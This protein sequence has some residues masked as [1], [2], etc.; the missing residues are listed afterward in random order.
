VFL[1]SVSDRI[2]CQVHGHIDVVQILIQHG[3]LPT[4]QDAKGFNCLCLALHHRAFTCA[5]W[6]LD[7]PFAGKLLSQVSIL[8]ETVLHIAV[9]AFQNGAAGNEALCRRIFF[10]LIKGGVSV[11]DHRSIQGVT[12][13][14]KAIQVQCQWFTSN[15]T[16]YASAATTDSILQRKF[17][18]ES[19]FILF[20]DPN[21]CD[22]AHNPMLY[23]AVCLRDTAAV[24]YIA[25]AGADVNRR[26]PDGW[27]PLLAAAA[28]GDGQICELLLNKS[29]NIHATLPAG[30]N[31]TPLQLAAAAG[32]MDVISRLLSRGAPLDTR[33]DL[34][35]NAVHLALL[36][37]Y[38]EVAFT[39]VS[40][41]KA[42]G[43]GGTAIAELICT[44]QPPLLHRILCSDLVESVMLKCVNMLLLLGFHIDDK[45]DEGR[46]PLQVALAENLPLVAAA[47]GS[48]A[49]SVSGD[50]RAALFSAADARDSVSLRTMIPHA[51][52]LNCREFFDHGRPLLHAVVRC[53][54]CR[55]ESVNQGMIECIGVMASNPQCN[56]DVADD[57]G[58]TPLHVA[59]A[60]GNLHAVSALLAAGAQCDSTS[61]SSSALLASLTSKDLGC[62]D[63]L[64]QFGAN[65]MSPLGPHG[66]LSCVIAAVGS[67][68]AAIVNRVME[69]LRLHHSNAVRLVCELQ[70]ATDGMTLPLL[71]LENSYECDEVTLEVLKS[72]ILGGSDALQCNHA[73]VYPAQI[74]AARSFQQTALFISSVAQSHLLSI[75]TSPSPRPQTRAEILK[76]IAG[77]GRCDIADSAGLLP[78]HLCAS[79]GSFVALEAL[80]SSSVMQG[81]AA[82]NS[83]DANGHNALC[84]AVSNGRADLLPILLR[85]KV[86]HLSSCGCSALAH[87]VVAQR[88]DC[89][90]V[91]LEHSGQSATSIIGRQ[92]PALGIDSL[93][94]ACLLGD[95][96]VVCALIE[97]S[98][99]PASIFEKRYDDGGSILHYL[100]S[101]QHH[102][103]ADAP[104]PPSVAAPHAA[105]STLLATALASAGAPFLRRN[106]QV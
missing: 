93:Q 60:L 43:K 53:S 88:T 71:W 62:V 105:V 102:K 40:S 101:L 86:S 33:N 100:A 79:I 32:A 8:G 103:R 23:V 78:L 81:A 58:C 97:A 2:S 72:L 27:T 76:C 98:K 55:G 42:A 20:S 85:G 49:K 45:D 47:L 15:L 90:G 1:L 41:A 35:L 38:R 37:G 56:I 13:V 99:S 106:S 51:S 36:H 61:L 68:S 12:A 59:V 6:L 83:T 95:V 84:H 18:S 14:E 73:S 5:A 87:A 31:C 104:E 22:H 52:D 50:T 28:V 66:P 46:T 4:H 54:G 19:P 25:S 91:M 16:E 63:Q 34:G 69:H 70:V 96:P 94:L 9:D 67:G 65:L 3:A 26:S 7:Q 39:L 82:I 77:G 64:L 74:A 80:M 89:I 29:A 92:N 10:N 11:F 17:D 48:H 24:Q 57:Q 75:L 21:A 44:P 30:Y